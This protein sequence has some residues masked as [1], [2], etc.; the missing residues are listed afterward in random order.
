LRTA[1]EGGA[2]VSYI[3]ESL[4]EGEQIVTRARFHWLYDLKAWLSVLV[5]A[6][7]LVAVLVYADEMT[8]EGLLIFATALLVVGLIGFLSLMISKWTTEIG[9][10][11]ARFVK[12]T[13]FLS[14]KTEEVALRNIEGVKVTQGLW[15]R[16]F[17]YG[18]IRIEGTGDDHVD[19][20]NIDD[21]VGFRRAIQTAK[22]MSAADKS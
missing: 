3:Q 1:E 13:G 19:L 18:S 6:V 4:G 14:L 21:P 8:R 9:V 16:L 12:K 10:T 17:G 11:S 22:G 7:I 20:P 5:P 15:G 2:S